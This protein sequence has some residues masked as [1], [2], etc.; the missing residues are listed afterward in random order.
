MKKVDKLDGKEEVQ[1]P[2]SRWDRMWDILKL[3]EPRVIGLNHL[4]H[5]SKKVKVPM[6]Y[7]KRDEKKLSA[8]LK[9]AFPDERIPI[10][11]GNRNLVY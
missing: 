3:L 7:T 4:N 1:L 10:F 11:R 2:F 8:L 5:E 6:S 9:L